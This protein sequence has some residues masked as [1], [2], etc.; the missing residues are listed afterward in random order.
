MNDVKKKV[1]Y[2][3]Y[4]FLALM[5]R[6][7]RYKSTLKLP[8]LSPHWVNDCPVQKR[9]ATGKLKGLFF[10]FTIGSYCYEMDCF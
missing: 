10:F 9:M 4:V 3:F 6:I 5:S 2:F 1:N 8:P 7:R